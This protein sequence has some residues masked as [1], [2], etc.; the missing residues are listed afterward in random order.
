[1]GYVQS[2]L[3][4]YT[5][6]DDQGKKAL[7]L[8][9]LKKNLRLE[10]DKWAKGE[11]EKKKKNPPP[12]EEKNNEEHT[13]FT[14]KLSATLWKNSLYRANTAKGLDARGGK[15]TVFKVDRSF[16]ADAYGNDTALVSLFADHYPY[17]AM[18]CNFNTEAKYTGKE[19][20]AE[21]DSKSGYA[22]KQQS[23]NKGK[24]A[25]CQMPYRWNA[26]HMIPGSAFYSEYVVDGKAVDIFT[27]EQYYLL[28]MSD[29]DVNNGNNMIPLPDAG[30]EFF[31]P[32]HKMLLHPSGHSNY[33]RH[34]Q[35]QL[36]EVADKLKKLKGEADKPHP[37]ISVK[38]AENIVRIENKCW[39]L[40][41]DLG[42]KTVTA[43][44]YKRKAK[45]SREEADLVGNS[46][47]AGNL[48]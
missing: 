43:Y 48:K 22:K 42:K 4:D 19:E 41:H 21:G 5:K 24:K 23:S 39:K 1:M 37:N 40:L 16:V 33:T 36:K 12:E 8:S 7:K 6:E 44:V 13:P 25:G 20:K 32:V 27:Q 35:K 28:L 31:Q 3:Q 2:Q 17:G 26:H 11:N 45:L 14:G 30:M 18:N 15:G 38:M 29:Y 10:V 9:Q 47:A 46:S 34:V